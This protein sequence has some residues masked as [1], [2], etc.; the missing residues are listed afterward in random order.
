MLDIKEIEDQIDREL[1]RREIEKRF[2]NQK[3][4]LSHKYSKNLESG[5]K[6]IS[7]NNFQ[8][9]TRGKVETISINSSVKKIIIKLN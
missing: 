4:I 3:S 8:S 1:L 5:K 7:T 9:R 2:N 6:I